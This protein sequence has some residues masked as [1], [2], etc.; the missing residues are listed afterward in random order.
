MS[1]MPEGAGGDGAGGT[2]K[3]GED[4]TERWL[5]ERRMS[6][7]EEFLPWIREHASI[8]ADADGGTGGRSGD[9]EPV[10]RVLEARGVEALRRALEAPGRV[11]ESAFRLLTADA[12]LTWSAEALLDVPD[13]ET[14]L[15]GLVRR[16]A[17]EDP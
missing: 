12:Y 14:A 1:R 3:T 17:G 10:G 9:E 11:R 13:P 8:S 15:E 4:A 16:V 2:G 6:V 7:P 5:A